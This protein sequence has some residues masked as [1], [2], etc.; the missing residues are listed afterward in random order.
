MSF[1]AWMKDKKHGAE[2]GFVLHSLDEGQNA[3]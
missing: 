3:R 1:I 2:P